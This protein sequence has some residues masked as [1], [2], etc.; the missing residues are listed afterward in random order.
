MIYLD[1]DLNIREIQNGY[2]LNIDSM[3]YYYPNF[4]SVLNALNEKIFQAQAEFYRERKPE[5]ISDLQVHPGVPVVGTLEIP[6]GA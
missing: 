1:I 5:D 2:L 6:T 3:Q 4:E